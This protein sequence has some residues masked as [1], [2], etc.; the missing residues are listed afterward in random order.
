MPMS[1]DTK[2][3]C[4]AW[5]LPRHNGLQISQVGDRKLSITWRI[6]KISQMDGSLRHMLPHLQVRASLGFVNG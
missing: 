1:I 6:W 3:D 2:E 5:V 4:N